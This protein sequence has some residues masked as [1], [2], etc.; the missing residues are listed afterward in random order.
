MFIIVQK[1]LIDTSVLVHDVEAEGAAVNAMQ[2]CV[3]TKGC[4]EPLNFQTGD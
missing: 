2:D 1:G 4:Q 3:K